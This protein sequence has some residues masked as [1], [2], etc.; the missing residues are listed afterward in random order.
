MWGALAGA[1]IFI[2]T[3]AGSKLDIFADPEAKSFLV[4]INLLTLAVGIYLALRDYKQKN[5]GSIS[6]GRCM[7]NGILIS[8]LAG[9]V[10]ALGI[11]VYYNFIVPEEKE[12]TLKEAETFLVQQKDSSSTTIEEYKQNFLKAYKDS[13]RTT[14]KDMPKIEQMVND[15]A[16]DI[17]EKLERTKGLYSVSGAV[18]TTTGPFVLVGLALSLLMA[19]VMA[20]RRQQ[21]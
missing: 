4:V 8:A 1:F 18:I 2:E 9:I 20:N 17:S 5:G 14:S 12:K 19:A 11:L 3:L 6:F 7:F 13:V 16:Q 21:Q 15:S 10:T